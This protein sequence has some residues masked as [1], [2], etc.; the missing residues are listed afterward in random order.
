[1]AA[2]QGKISAI[3][4]AIQLLLALPHLVVAMG[5]IQQRT[6]AMMEIQAALAVVRQPAVAQAVRVLAAKE[7]PAQ[8]AAAT[9]QGAVA[10]KTVAVVVIQAVRDLHL[11]SPDQASPMR[12]AVMQKAAA[13]AQAARVTEVVVVMEV[14]TAPQV[15]QVLLWCVTLAHN[16]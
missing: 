12:R 2:T 3:T 9:A 11:R 14:F 8:T 7:A 5:V 10:V 6:A 16:A 4:A 15:V 1:V 13:P